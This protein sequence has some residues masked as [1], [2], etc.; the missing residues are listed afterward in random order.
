MNFRTGDKKFETIGNDFGY[1]TEMGDII[2]T[3]H[4]EKNIKKSA[5]L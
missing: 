3:D 5:T 4:S 2:Y 1:F